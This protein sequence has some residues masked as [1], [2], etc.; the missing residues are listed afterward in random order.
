MEELLIGSSVL[1]LFVILLR[2]VMGSKIS[3]RMRYA[4][5]LIVAL[6][7]ALPF[8]LPGSPL[9]IMNYVPSLQA[10]FYGEAESPGYAGVRDGGSTAA[11]ESGY[12]DDLPPGQDGKSV[13]LTVRQGAAVVRLDDTAQDVPAQN[14]SMRQDAW[15]LQDGAMVRNTLTERASG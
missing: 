9:S 5:W 2:T 10:L 14:V 6:R 13:I 12:G 11:G 4:L 15:K 3:F 8:A 1:I 7:L